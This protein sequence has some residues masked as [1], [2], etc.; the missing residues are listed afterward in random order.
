MHLQ[1]ACYEKVEGVTRSLC[2][3]HCRRYFI[4]SIPLDSKGKETPNSK[5]AE[6]REFINL[7]FKLGDEM[8]DL[9]N[10]K[11]KEKRQEASRV[12]LDAF[13][14]WV[15]KI[16]KIPTTN[17]KLTTAL[18]YVQNQ[19]KYLETFLKDGRLEISNNLCESH[20]RPFATSRRAWLFADTPK[21][22]T[23]NAILYTLVETAK[24]NKLNVYEY[25][26]CL[27]NVM[28]NTDFKNNPELIDNYLPWADNL[29]KECRLTNTYK[30]CLN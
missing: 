18:G 3:A 10:E 2:W 16:S 21:G 5:G 4:E 23:A 13:W 26:H 27:L 8:K 25:L 17:E 30:K 15:E 28:P 11:R 24:A 1:N 19:R 6:G 22:A 20:I 7:L 12:I 14:S 9:S 29:P